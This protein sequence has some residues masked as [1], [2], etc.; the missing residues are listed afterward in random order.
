MN[1]RVDPAF[2]EQERAVLGA[3]FAR[4][5]EAAFTEGAASFFS[6]DDLRQ[7]QGRYVELDADSITDAVLAIDPAFAGDATGVAV[8]GRSRADRTRLLVA[9]VSRHQ[10]PRSRSDRRRAKTEQE[11]AEVRDLVLD[12]VSELANRFRVGTIVTD[13]HLS[14]T[15]VQGLRERGH[16]RVRVEAWTPKT[17]TRAFA[18]IRGRVLAGTIEFPADD[19]LIAELTRIRTRSHGGT[20]SVEIPRSVSGHMDSALAVAAGVLFFDRKTPARPARTLS[21][22]G[23]NYIPAGVEAEL[24]RTATWSVR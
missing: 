2:V 5:Y 10:P 1:P 4:E 16:D 20:P 9:H 18:A 17:L 7:V 19:V 15:V 14:A 12:A 24:V 13:Q 8:V 3:D 22:F 23:P 11:V 21:S 6:A